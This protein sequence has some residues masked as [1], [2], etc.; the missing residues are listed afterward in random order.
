MEIW[1][2]CKEEEKAKN[3]CTKRIE[4]TF[5]FLDKEMSL[6][7]KGNLS[8]QAY[9][10]PTQRIQYVNKQSAYRKSCLKSIPKEVLKRLSRLTSKDLKH[11]SNQ[12]IK[13]LYLEHIQAL[14]E[15]KLIPNQDIPEIPMMRNLWSKDEKEKEEK[16]NKHYKEHD[17]RNVYLV[18][19]FSKF[20]SDLP[21]P[22]HKTT[23][24]IIEI[25]NLAW[26]RVCMTYRRF[27]S[28]GEI[29]QAHLTTKL[30]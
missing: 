9:V 4:P 20:W 7:K 17:R 29:L 18:L 1:K 25:N 19:G 28:L 5:P 14:R 22:L 24:K 13:D 30:Q 16:R 26:L 6:N 8:F 11:V 12:R 10:K 27:R 2:P 23:N 15:A 21:E 3:K